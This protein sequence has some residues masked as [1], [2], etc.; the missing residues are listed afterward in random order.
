MWRLLTHWQHPMFRKMRYR[1][2]V[3]QRPC[4]RER[5]PSTVC[6]PPLV[7]CFFSGGGRRV[8]TLGALSDE[9][10]SLIAEIGRRAMIC[11][12]FMHSRSAENY[13]SVPTCFS[14]N[15]AFQCC[16]PCQHVPSLCPHRNQSGHTF[17]AFANY[18]S[19]WNADG[20]AMRILSVRPY[21]CPSVL[22]VRLSNAWIVTK[23]KKDLSRFSY[24]TKDHLA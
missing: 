24:D 8:E 3:L 21:I 12:F 1:Q 5:R 11:S 14:G 10:H 23:R 15:S 20:L 17:F 16:V 18:R 7:T 19:A 22:D 4:L 9:A 2:E 6:S 13:V